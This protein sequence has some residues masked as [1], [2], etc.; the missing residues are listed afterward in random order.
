[1]DYPKE[2]SLLNT[3][4]NLLEK[5]RHQKGTSDC[6]ALSLASLIGD[7][8]SIEKN[9]L[10]VYPSSIHIAGYANECKNNMIKYKLVKDDNIELTLNTGYEP[11]KFLTCAEIL[12]YPI[13]TEECFPKIDTIKYMTK[14]KDL[15]K[16]KNIPLKNLNDIC[17]NCIQKVNNKISCKN[18]NE[19]LKLLYSLEFY[20]K[21][22]KNIDYELKKR[23]EYTSNDIINIHNMIK[24]IIFNVRKPILS[25]IRQT[26]DYTSYFYYNKKN[27]YY[28]PKNSERLIGLHSI[29]ILGWETYKGIEYWICRDTIFSDR[30]VKI[31]FS[32]YDN[33]NNWIGPDI[34]STDIQPQLFPFYIDIQDFDLEPFLKGKIIFK[35]LENELEKDL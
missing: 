11:N 23:S 20:I 29:I 31:A 25:T 4:P 30:F 32:N 35:N 1:M 9:I 16:S 34:F 7:T 2:F 18:T 27:E 8:F 15:D 12:K 19:N 22:K 26:Y 17:K 3:Y 21:N 5:T 10:P 6:W 28:I 33:K 14:E 13:R 24:N